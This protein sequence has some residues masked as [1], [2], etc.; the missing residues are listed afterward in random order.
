MKNEPLHSG[1]TAFS[2]RGVD[3]TQ[4]IFISC[5][6]DMGKNLTVFEFFILQSGGTRV[7]LE[8]NA[9]RFIDNFSNGTRGSASAEYPYNFT[10]T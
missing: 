1:S 6:H 9:V 5:T 2:F 8:A 10:Y 4:L 7:P 3:L